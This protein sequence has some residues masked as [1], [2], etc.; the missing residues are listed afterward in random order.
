MTAFK[1][2]QMAFTRHIRDPQN[3]S[4]PEGV[5]ERGMAVYTEIVFNNI[6]SSVAACFPVLKKVLGE[7]I[8]L[9]LVR[10]FFIHQPCVTPIF[11]EIPEAFLEYINRVS[12][13][14]PYVQNLAHYEW[15]ELYLAYADETI[16]WSQIDTEADLL[17]LPLA[18]VPAMA[19]LSYDY[20]VHKISSENIP[21][22]PLETP[23]NLLVFRN[24]DDDVKF[25]ELNPMTA[26]LIE[27]LQDGQLSAREALIGIASV[28]AFDDVDAIVDFGFE[29]LR[30]LKSQGAILGVLNTNPD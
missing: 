25:V 9:R 12:G 3:A 26:A 4:P 8:W 23:V 6:E 21:E 7:D 24:A 1:D 13:L 27:D 17:D 30:D 10:E 16:D 2:Y 29:L 15:V 22:S 14:P 19:L 5:S 18:F 20:P 28:M 11:R